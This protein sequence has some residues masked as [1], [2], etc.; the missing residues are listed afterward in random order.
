MTQA[1]TV[2]VIARKLDTTYHQI[3]YLIK[4]R[5]IRPTLR[6]GNLRV[7][8]EAAE[9]QIAAELAKLKAAKQG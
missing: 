8:D 5:G 1:L 2:G 9:A 7:F 4:A 3:D 6:A